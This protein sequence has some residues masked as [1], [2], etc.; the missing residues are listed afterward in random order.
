MSRSSELSPLLSRFIKS[1]F[2]IRITFFRGGKHS[3]NRYTSGLWTLLDFAE[4]YWTS[5]EFMNSSDF[6]WNLS[7]F[8]G[9]HRNSSEFTKIGLLWTSSDFIWNLS[10]FI[11]IHWNSSESMNSSDFTGLHRIASD[12]IGLL[13]DCTPE[14]KSS[15]PLSFLFMPFF[16]YIYINSF[17]FILF[18]I[19]AL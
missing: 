7:D 5:S 11:R 14:F 6:T 19:Y 10:N 18:I 12:I 13:T 9:L 17:L 4:I 16:I 1:S 8:I 15:Y 2:W 3:K